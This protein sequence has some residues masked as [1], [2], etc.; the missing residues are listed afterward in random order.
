MPSCIPLA[1]VLEASLLVPVPEEA[2]LGV[3][4][5]VA[6]LFCAAAKPVKA[7]VAAARM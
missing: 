3:L 5:V 4:L 2:P 7:S 6:E 1:E